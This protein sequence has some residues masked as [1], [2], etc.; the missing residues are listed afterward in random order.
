MRI[1]H[2]IVT[3]VISL[4]L[5]GSARAERSVT[6]FVA[7]TGSPTAEDVERKLD[8]LASVGID[9]FMFYPTSGMRMD[10]LGEDFFR[11]AENFAAGAERRGMKM[12][13]YD[14]YNWPSGT[15]R[16][17][18][19]SENERWRYTEV[20]YHRNPTGGVDR[21]LTHGPRGWGTL[22]EPDAVDRFV[23]LTYGAYERR[24]GKWIRNGTIP[25]VFT[26]EPGHPVTV[27]TPPKPIR[28]CRWWSAL[29]E[30]YL[31][32][33]GRSFDADAAAGTVDYAAYARLF[34]RCFRTSYF[35]RIRRVA[36]R[37]GIRFCGHLICD[38]SASAALSTNGD[39]LLALRGESFP[40]IDEISAVIAPDRIPFFLYALGDHAIS[41]NGNGGMAELLACGP[42]DMSPERM[43]RMVWLCALHGVT[44]YFLVMSAMDMSWMEQMRGFSTTV[45]EYQPWFAAFG[46][47]LDEADRASAFARKRF[48]RDAAVRYPN[49]LIA[50]RAFRGA[51]TE[52]VDSLLRE[53]ELEGFSPDL[54]AQD[55]RSELPVVFS[56]EDEAIVEER[57]GCRFAD[58]K[59]AVRY[60]AERRPVVGRRRNVLL[61]RCE[62][63]TRAELDL[64]PIVPRSG[65]DCLGVDW[66]VALDSP[67]RHRVNFDTN[68][69]GRLRLAMPLKGV[70]LA[71]R[72]HIPIP[73]LEES[74]LIA[75]GSMCEG[76][77]EQ[78]PPY[79]LELDG[80]MLSATANSN[81]LR[82][83]FDSLYGMTEPMELAAGDHELR[84]VS[85]RM[86]D[87]YYLPVAVAAGDFIERDGVLEPLP[88]KL[89]TGP[90]A[91]AGLAGFAGAVTYSAVVDI[92]AG[93]ALDVASGN[94]F[95][96]VR[97]DG[98]DLGV[99]A[100]EPFVWTIP[101]SLAGKAR[102]L[103][104]TVYT[105]V[106]PIF[107]DA[108]APCAK[109][110]RKLM[111]RRVPYE[112]NPGLLAV[113]FRDAD[114]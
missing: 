74:D 57:S 72:R 85:G 79:R 75:Y 50:R 20:S 37:L 63:G 83:G 76:M 56:F 14:E 64:A 65:P 28:R 10:Y 15:C 114:P 24:L 29:P 110:K 86:D 93:K 77:G 113:S 96:R 5:C 109:W 9:S 70:R 97:I 41:R 49:D 111:A 58:A 36:D 31:A 73:R 13:L 106:M 84:I 81:C 4:V 108:D 71:V 61:R 25:G 88:E 92:P 2:C 47:F 21:V 98:C 7:I 67:N 32:E 12:W 40:G 11:C 90:L 68:G 8:A 35:D 16:G 18:V 94:A 101:E 45:G 105:S 54:I 95:T 22:L 17:R 60:L 44:R 102:R 100:W 34:G 43:R 33:T 66:R 6:M 69:I 104:I 78:P 107:G 51:G 91:S 99:R 3:G 38:S 42:A 26:D 89:P 103:E 82:P 19:P 48:V 80:K 59:S 112:S 30:T 39:P 27:R 87:N 55:E 1:F 46:A 53:I 62:D 52:S 23:E